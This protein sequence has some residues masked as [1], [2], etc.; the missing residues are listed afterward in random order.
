MAIVSRIA[1]ITGRFKRRVMLDVTCSVI[2][3]VGLANLWW[4]GVV[5]P[6]FEMFNTFDKKMREVTMAEEK[7][8]MKENA[9]SREEGSL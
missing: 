2:A 5:I 7:E 6:K 9:Y 4:Y 1:P 3:G 8:W